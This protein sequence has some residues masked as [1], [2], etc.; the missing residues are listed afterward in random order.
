MTILRVCGKQRQYSPH[1]GGTTALW[2]RSCAV[3][4]AS[5][6]L[7]A[8]VFS[9]QTSRHSK[10]GF[11]LCSY[12]ALRGIGLIAAANHRGAEDFDSRGSG[13]SRTGGGEIT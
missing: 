9:L 2:M 11:G 7:G 12:V 13:R 6:S 10:V 3:C 1:G 8:L 5:D 4:R